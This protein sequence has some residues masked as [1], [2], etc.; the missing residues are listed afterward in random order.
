MLLFFY[1]FIYLFFNLVSRHI[2]VKRLGGRYSSHFLLELFG[3]W[4]DIDQTPVS[5]IFV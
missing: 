5:V 3:I 1:S 4:N 2:D